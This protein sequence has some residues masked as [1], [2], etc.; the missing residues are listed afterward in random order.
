MRVYL[1]GPVTGLS[2]S[3]ALEWREYA[4]AELKLAGITAFSPM[5]AKQ[6]L[7]HIGKLSPTCEGYTHLSSPRS[8]M[9][10]DRWDATRCEVMLV[11]LLGAT[12][13]SIGTVMEIAWAD[14][15]R[16]P[17]ILAIE[18]EGNPHEHAMIHEAIGY[19]VPTLIEALT[20]VQHMLLP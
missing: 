18:N 16:I 17:I 13:V 3:G 1:A 14:L 7:T 15:S 5:R 9:T 19:R 8:I 10:R 11:N 12:Q 4:M 2:Y 6:H 20:I